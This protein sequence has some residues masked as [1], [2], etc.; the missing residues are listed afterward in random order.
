M[1][2]LKNLHQV[3]TKWLSMMSPAIRVMNEYRTLVVKMLEDQNQVAP[4]RTSFEH[5]IDRNF[6][7]LPRSNTEIFASPDA[8]WSEAG[9]V[10]L[11]L[12]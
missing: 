3:K 4:T 11:R 2:G 5:L 10:Y 9:R 1:K 12:P 8:A 6:P 7:I